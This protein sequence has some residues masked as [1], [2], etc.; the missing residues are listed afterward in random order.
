M[1]IKDYALGENNTIIWEASKCIH[2]AECIKRLPRVFNPRRR[3]WI[4]V[5]HA[6]EED[7]I[8]TVKN[9]PSGA[10]SMKSVQAE[11]N[12]NSSNSIK[13][14]SNK[15]VISHNGP[16]LIEGDFEITLGA[17]VLEKKNKMYICR[18]HQSA[19]KPYCDG[20]HKKITFE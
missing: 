20:T 11:N 6:S 9:C 10:L 13:S 2:S 15:I 14:S 4:E 12:E 19:N 8:R 3:P 16:M 18:C 17:D 1:E 7:I 5:Q